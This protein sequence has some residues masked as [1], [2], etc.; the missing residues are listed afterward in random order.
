[1]A[2]LNFNLM[3]DIFLFVMMELNRNSIILYNYKIFFVKQNVKILER[4][5]KVKNLERS[6]FNFIRK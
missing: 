6:F 4:L 1:M 5:K 3:L 2:S